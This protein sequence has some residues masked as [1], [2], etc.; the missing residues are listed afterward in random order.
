[1][2]G[3]KAERVEEALTAFD[4]SD[5]GDT[6]RIDYLLGAEPGGGVY[7]I[8]KVKDSLPKA[9]QDF[10][11]NY[12]KV[13][14]SP[15]GHYHLLYRPYHLCHLETPKAIHS[16][17]NGSPILATQSFTTQVYAYAKTDLPPATQ[18]K[19][20]IGSAEVYGSVEPL[21]SNKIPIALL[22][23]STTLK[24]GLKQDQAL[25][26]DHLDLPNTKLTELWHQQ[27]KTLS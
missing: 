25:T 9:E 19:H 16:V 15:C 4:F 13:S 7:L 1:M 24:T 21:N 11:L 3:P 17:V 27:Q 23:E 20:A 2:T 6:P 10:Y 22:E 8:V 5:Y 12:Y 26:P 14:A 18:I